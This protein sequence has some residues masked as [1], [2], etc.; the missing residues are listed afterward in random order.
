MDIVRIKET[1]HAKHLAQCLAHSKPSINNDSFYGEQMRWW[2]WKYSE[3]HKVLYKSK[4]PIICF[5]VLQWSIPPIE[6]LLPTLSF[7]KYFMCPIRLWAP[8][9]KDWS[10]YSVLATIE[11]DTIVTHATAYI[12]GQLMSQAEVP[13]CLAPS[14][15]SAPY[16]WG[17]HRGKLTLLL[18]VPVVCYAKWGQY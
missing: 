9:G 2:M 1:R 17:S 5:P 13:K 10:S 7:S 6:G 8:H 14:D 12:A 15:D 18:W 4:V 11:S 16:R 3:S